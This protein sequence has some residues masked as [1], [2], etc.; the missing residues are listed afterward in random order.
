MNYTAILLTVFLFLASRPATG[1]ASGAGRAADIV[2]LIDRSRS[3]ELV[4]REDLLTHGAAHLIVDSALA[5]SALS[6]APARLA[7]AEFGDDVREIRPLTPLRGLVAIAGPESRL[8]QTDFRPALQF[9][10]QSLSSS[11]PDVRR[12]IFLLTD[13]QPAFESEAASRDDLMSDGVASSI[14]ALQDSGAEIFLV[15]I[16][17]PVQS[18][19]AW[20]RLLPED[21]YLPLNGEADFVRVGAQLLNELTGRRLRLQFVAP[22]ETPL[23]FFFSNSV[24]RPTLLLALKGSSQVQVSLLDPLS[25]PRSPTFGNPADPHAFFL[26]RDD[27]PGLWRLAVRGEAAWVGLEE[28]PTAPSGPATSATIPTGLL[29]SGAGLVLVCLL[30]LFLSYRLGHRHRSDRIRSPEQIDVESL[31]REA[32]QLV[33]QRRLQEAETKLRTALD[34]VFTRASAAIVTGTD[35]LWR[36]LEKIYPNQMEKQRRILEEQLHSQPAREAV[37][38]VAQILRKRWQ[39]KPELFLTEFYSF[40]D[41]PRGALLVAEL[42]RMSSEGSPF[43]LFLREV[44]TQTDRIQHWMDDE[45]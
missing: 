21:H 22:Q 25:H 6:G 17:T 20:K 29:V 31:S 2:L 43:G 4:D 16:R 19:T 10:R 24:T 5:T 30:S 41:S 1:V 9:A 12:L 11:G 13:G 28:A 18:A 14:A 33:E 36:I 8:K 42:S 27:I 45:P 35:I 39:E 38:A 23:P 32:D 15:A 44:A 3:L 26:I 7:I 40:R 37:Q 34:A